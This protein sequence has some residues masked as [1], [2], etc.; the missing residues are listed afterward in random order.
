M[1]RYRHKKLDWVAESDKKMEGMYKVYKSPAKTSY[2]LRHALEIEDS[3]DWE[4][5]Y[6]TLDEFLDT[7]E[8]EEEFLG[9]LY[10]GNGETVL[11]LLEK[12]ID[13]L[14]NNREV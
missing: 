1:K 13:L 8:T 3:N 5:E 4:R 9:D 12:A 2:I 6:D 10:S 7:R 14:K 11:D